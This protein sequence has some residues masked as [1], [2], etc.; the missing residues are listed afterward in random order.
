MKNQGLDLETVGEP[1]NKVQQNYGVGPAGHGDSD[2]ITPAQHAITRDD[3][4]HPLD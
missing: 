3:S 4:R 1:I 2:A